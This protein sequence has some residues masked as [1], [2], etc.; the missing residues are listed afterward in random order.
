MNKFIPTFL[1]LACFILLAGC[2]TQ[3]ALDLREDQSRPDFALLEV[4]IEIDLIHVNQRK[5]KVKALY[6]A[7]VTYKLSPGVS[8]IGFQYNNLHTN[9]DGEK[10]TIKSHVVQI[11]FTAEAGKT[12]QVKYQA[13]RTFDDAVALEDKFQLSLYQDQQAIAQSSVND[14][15]NTAQPAPVS[16]KPTTQTKKPADD[17]KP[18]EHLYYWWQ[19]AT[20]PEKQQFLQFIES[21]AE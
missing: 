14:L 12:Y 4:P 6:R 9:P 11:R 13:P 2:A 18:L 17:A 7:M 5:I 20:G 21:P 10:E 16:A 19:T 15:W 3:K 1:L 8:I